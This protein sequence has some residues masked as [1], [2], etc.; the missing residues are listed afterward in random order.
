MEEEF[1]AL[2]R[3]LLRQVEP[4]PERLRRGREALLRA[5]S[6]PEPPPSSRR[7]GGGRSAPSTDNT[8]ESGE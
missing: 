2:Y 6:A 5:I 7:S 4:D 1:A 3:R 8:R